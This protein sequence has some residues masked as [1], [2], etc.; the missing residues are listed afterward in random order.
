MQVALISVNC[1]RCAVGGG[2]GEGAKRVRGRGLYSRVTVSQLLHL[3]NLALCNTELTRKLVLR[4]RLFHRT[5]IVN[6]NTGYSEFGA[7]QCKQTV[8]LITEIPKL[9][10]LSAEFWSKFRNSLHRLG[11]C[12]ICWETVVQHQR[13]LVKTKDPIKRGNISVH[14][15]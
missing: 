15:Y 10:W 1:F 13:L 3:I 9:I 11:N 8:K 14:V 5:C 6:L 7:F 2:S 4:E 12:N